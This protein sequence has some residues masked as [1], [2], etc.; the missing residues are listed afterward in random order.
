MMSASV[1]I[2]GAGVVGASVAY[3]LAA[4]GWRDI[5]VLERAP[6]P[7]QGSTGFATGGYRS[8]FSTPIHIRLSRLAREKLHH[9]HEETGVDPGFRAVGYLWLATDTKQMDALGRIRTLHAQE[10]ETDDQEFD[11]EAAT[12]FNSHVEVGEVVGGVFCPSAGLVEP[13]RILDG[14]LAAASR[15]GVQVECGAEVTG[16]R[17]STSGCI[18]AVVTSKH[19][20]ATEFVV[21]A[22]GAWAGSL[23][24]L[25]GVE[26]PVV[27]L[28]RQV[29]VTFPFDALSE[30]MPMTIFLGDG[31]HA[32][33]RNGRA[34]LLRPSPGSPEDPYD[35]SVDPSW[36]R[37]VYALACRRI[38]VLHGTSVDNAASYAGLYEMSPDKHALV[39]KA[40]GCDNLILANGSSGHGVMHAPALG[41]LVSEILSDGAARALNIEALRPSRFLEG[42]PNPTDS[43]L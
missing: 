16:L 13:L 5:R 31:F 9:F 35:T 14:Y 19:E 40:P 27:P 38:P 33:V 17:R 30:D 6:R 15:L 12:R 25:A 24:S 39:G 42:K 22:A 21:N 11:A 20:I 2:V 32:R 34:L 1:V 43:L 18:E 28:R 37:E 29:A 41:Q 10:G 8:F 4:R 23:A 26:L 3:H 7:G 36:I